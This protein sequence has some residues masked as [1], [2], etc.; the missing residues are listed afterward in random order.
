MQSIKSHWLMLALALP[1]VL[2]AQTIIAYDV[3]AGTFSDQF[4]TNPLGLDFDVVTSI[5]VFSLGI[6]DSG[7]DGLTFAHVV[8][9]YDRSTQLAVATVTI[10]A[11]TSAQLINGSRFVAL[12]T[13]LVLPAGFQGSIVAELNTTDGNGNT[14]GG[15]GI[16]TLN[17]GGGAIA[18]VGGGRVSDFGPGVYPLR[19]DGGPVNRYLAG[20]FTFS[21]VPEPSTY[22]LLACGLGVVWLFRRRSVAQSR[23][24]P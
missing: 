9:I 16:S 11:G 20:T 15:G 5:T 24:K 10:P 23:V 7:Q 22:A 13:P 1:G 19:L 2:P 14:N 8:D 6:F 18:F 3:P 12:A 4:I 21:P 17:T